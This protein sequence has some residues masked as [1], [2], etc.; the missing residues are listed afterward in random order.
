M[1]AGA[2]TKTNDSFDK[3]GDTMFAQSRYAILY[4]SIVTNT[5]RILVILK[6]RIYMKKIL[7]LCSVSFILSSCASVPPVSERASKWVDSLVDETQ[8]I[9]N[10]LVGQKLYIHPSYIPDDEKSVFRYKTYKEALYDLLIENKKDVNYVPPLNLRYTVRSGNRGLYRLFSSLPNKSIYSCHMRCYIDSYLFRTFDGKKFDFNTPITILDV[11]LNVH[12]RR[13]Y[14]Q[15]CWTGFYWEECTDHSQDMKNYKEYDSF[16]NKNAS[17]ESDLMLLGVYYEFNRPEYVV[18]FMDK[19]DSIPPGFDSEETHFR[20]I[21]E[22]Q[23]EIKA[24]MALLQAEISKNRNNKPERIF[25]NLT[26]LANEISKNQ[27]RFNSQYQGKWIQVNNI[28]VEE[29]GKDYMSGSQPMQ[30]RNETIHWYAEGDP[31]TDYNKFDVGNRVNLRCVF[32]NSK[33]HHHSFSTLYS[34]DGDIAIGGIP[35]TLDISLSECNI[36]K[37]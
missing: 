16:K 31:L 6:K 30:Y 33:K 12:N 21:T 28:S 18:I 13:R 24:D 11:I 35:P 34:S 19:N 14:P 26:A 25:T 20:F 32:K 17:L 2:A 7:L 4:L 8:P 36:R 3:I 37:R 22:A 10:R 15:Y 27:E 23:E 5:E 9:K 1:R 29:I